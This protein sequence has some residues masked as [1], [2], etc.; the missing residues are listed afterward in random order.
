MRTA[1]CG[2]QLRQPSHSAKTSAVLHSIKPSQMLN[3]VLMRALQPAKCN[4]LRLGQGKHRYCVASQA[5]I[6]ATEPA[7]S[8]ATLEVVF[9]A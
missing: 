1:R 3:R 8:L 5:S 7:Q 2:V 6:A 4:A 9:I